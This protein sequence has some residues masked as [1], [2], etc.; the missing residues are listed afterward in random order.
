V[1]AISPAS[2]AELKATLWAISDA[3]GEPRESDWTVAWQ[4]GPEESAAG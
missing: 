2:Y 3:A 1:A 4:A